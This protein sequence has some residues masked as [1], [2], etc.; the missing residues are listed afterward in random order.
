MTADCPIHPEYCRRIS[1]R[2]LK[3][4]NHTT[5]S[6]R[7]MALTSSLKEMSAPRV[8]FPQGYFQTAQ[9]PCTTNGTVHHRERNNAPRATNKR[10]S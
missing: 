1:H 2:A 4:P 7:N 8:A 5:T 6:T 9:Q 3:S 10:Y